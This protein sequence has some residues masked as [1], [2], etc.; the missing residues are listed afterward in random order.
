MADS[1]HSSSRQV[2]CIPILNGKVCLV[3]SRNRKRWVFP[4]GSIP[5]GKTLA[6]AALQ[7]AWEEAGIT[8]SL[9]AQPL[10]TYSYVK[11]KKPYLVTVF[12]MSVTRQT[13]IFPEQFIRSKRWVSVPEA[14]EMVSECELKELL[15]SLPL[16][17]ALTLAGKSKPAN[18]EPSVTGESSAII[19]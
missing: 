2:A 8:G 13:D 1:Q 18:S 12:A 7:E 17:P 5:K 14:M 9:G 10:G 6:E 4:K 3:S 15:Q 19:A 16:I 11:N